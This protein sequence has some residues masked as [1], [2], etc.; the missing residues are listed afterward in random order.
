M[1]SRQLPVVLLGGISLVRTLGMAGIPAIVATSNGDEPALSSRYCRTRYRI[2]RLDSGAPA[3]DALVSLGGRLA[4]EHGRRVPLMYGSDDAL[5]LINAHRERLERYF[6]LLLN[7]HDVGGALIA[8]D[9]F[10]AFAAS[11]GLPVPRS[12]AWAGDGPGTVRGTP[13]P[14]VAKPSEKIDWH[15]SALCRD[16]FDGDGKA[17]VFATGQEAADH[18][19]LGA[20]H[21][22][23]TFQEYVPGGHEELWSYHGFADENGEVLAAFTGRKIRTFPAVTGESAYIEVAHDPSLE[24][25]GRDIVRRC[26]LKGVFKM[27]F[28]RDP[29]TGRWYLLE[30]NARCNLWLFLGASNGLNLMRVA[31]DYLVDG[32]RPQAG[33]AEAR[34]RWIAF[35]LDYRAYREM[36][37]RGEITFGRWIASLAAPKVYNLFSVSDPLPWL[38]FWGHRFAR[39]G[40]SG[41]RRLAR[42]LRQWRATAS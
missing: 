38:A 21:A 32:V 24:A 33:R 3:A 19:G 8:K 10:Q 35:E 23:L 5:E 11:R 15:H 30:I 13:G 42:R 28:K 40:R 2:P 22:K 26:P 29:A 1:T 36:A 6:L 17:L 9:R 18:A 27:D 25:V 20:H 7:D 14:V 4:A 31:Y 39:H 37:A 12:L 34:R 41:P 16:L